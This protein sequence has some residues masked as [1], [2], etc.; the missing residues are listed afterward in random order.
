[1]SRIER[2]LEK[3][4]I[5]RNHGAESK[6]VVARESDASITV[7]RA[8]PPLLIQEHVSELKINDPVISTCAD[9]HSP[10]SEEYRKLKS[11]IV[12]M[13]KQ[14]GFRNT[15]MVCSSV[16]SEG[17]SITSINL[18]VTLAQEHDHT[19]LLVDADLRKPSIHGI[20][21]LQPERG[22]VDCLTGD[23]DVSD[24]LIKTG[25]GRLT[26]LPA[27]TPLRNPVE[28][29][30]SQVMKE[31]VAELKHRYPDRY[32]IID[33]PPILPFAETRFLGELVD[34]IVFV[35]R[36]GQ[37]SLAD[38]SEA[39]DALPRNKLLG[40]VYN[41]TN[42][43]KFGDRYYYYHYSYHDQSANKK[44]TNQSNGF[45]RKMFRRDTGK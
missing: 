11:A 31:M 28:L 15:I 32:I 41:D 5:L 37:A 16:G 40:I 25:I 7:Q 4:N 39:I 33:T 20:L 45:F 1:M 23:T 26:F 30:S 6:P 22:L 19:V 12:T 2:A 36:E 29:L 43:E 18:A 8:K 34:G 38:V 27:G 17:K 10:V 14:D 13:T 3:A 42:V 24:V 9:P 35:V 21:G 44:A